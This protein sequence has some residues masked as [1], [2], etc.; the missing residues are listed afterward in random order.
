MKSV[1]LFAL[2]FAAPFAA[3]DSYSEQEALAGMLSAAFT[4]NLGANVTFAKVSDWS[5]YKPRFHA[6]AATQNNIERYLFDLRYPGD[7]IGGYSKVHTANG[8]DTTYE[9]EGP[10]GTSR[11]KYYF[12]FVC[13]KGSYQYEFNGQGEIL[14]Y[15]NMSSVLATATSACNE[16]IALPETGLPSPSP[17]PEPSAEPSEEPSI[18][19]SPS[20]EPTI[21]PSAEPS[22]EPTEEPSAEASAEPTLEPNEGPAPSAAPQADDPLML[23]VAGAALLAGLAAVIYYGFK[24]E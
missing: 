7:Y 12:E 6:E 18:E 19:P 3:A 1:L 5:P 15:D 10:P 14:Y 20:P 17:S 22:I 23:A 2:L 24:R 16:F 13:A 21:E 8:I 9:F 11:G 4:A